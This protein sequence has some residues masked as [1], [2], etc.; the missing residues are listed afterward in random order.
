MA[1]IKYGRI[2]KPDIKRATWHPRGTFTLKVKMCS[3][4]LFGEH[5]HCDHH[6][7]CS[8]VCREDLKP[9]LAI[10]HEDMAYRGLI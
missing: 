6:F 9:E 8:C 2:E 7:L 4:C 5:G 1:S 3:A 10:Q